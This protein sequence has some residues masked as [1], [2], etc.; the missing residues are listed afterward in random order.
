MLSLQNPRPCWY[1]PVIPFCVCVC[2]IFS[3]IAQRLPSSSLYTGSLP[4]PTDAASHMSPPKPLQPQRRSQALQSQHASSPSSS[5]TVD[6]ELRH[7]DLFTCDPPPRAAAALQSPL[8]PAAL[9]QKGSAAEA[10]AHDDDFYYLLDNLSSCSSSDSERDGGNSSASFMRVGNAGAMLTAA[11]Q[12]ASSIM[13]AIDALKDGSRQPSALQLHTRPPEAGNGLPFAGLID[14]ASGEFR[15]A[16]GTPSSHFVR[17]SPSDAI[18]AQLPRLYPVS[19][20]ELRIKRFWDKKKGCWCQ[21]WAPAAAASSERPPTFAS[22]KKKNGVSFTVDTSHAANAATNMSPGLDTGGSGGSGSKYRYVDSS[23]SATTS[24]SSPTLHV[25]IVSASAVTSKAAQQPFARS[26]TSPS[27]TN[28]RVEAAA[29]QGNSSLHSGISFL[30]HDAK[31]I[32]ASASAPHLWR[33]WGAAAVRVHARHAVS[34]S[35]LYREIRAHAENLDEA[36]HH[37]AESCSVWQHGYSVL[38][39]RCAATCQR[40]H[41]LR[42]LR[43]LFN[44]WKRAVSVRTFTLRAARQRALRLPKLKQLVHSWRLLCISSRVCASVATMFTTR[45][46]PR[47]ADS[48]FLFAFF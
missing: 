33:S 20:P 48:A 13:R 14:A 30:G 23:L 5:S 8:Q 17:N 39:L 29:G 19:A 27:F 40:L 12:G 6:Q 15:L 35:C 43:V 7:E 25:G 16:A 41:V 4:D 37:L 22:A 42:L 26:S 2:P 45:L 9:D 32:A 28:E 11:G 1:F 47:H 31:S 3:C 34:A 10:A 44:V 38:Q 18:N 36:L 21:R 24:A 46:A